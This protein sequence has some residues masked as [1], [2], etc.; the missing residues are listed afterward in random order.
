MRA[1]RYWGLYNDFGA[2]FLKRNLQTSIGNHLGPYSKK[3]EPGTASGSI[4]GPR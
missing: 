4:Q 1:L 3:K 2:I